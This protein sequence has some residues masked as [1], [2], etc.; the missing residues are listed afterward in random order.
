MI[1]EVERTSSAKK[2]WKSN[3]EE[4]KAVEETIKDETIEQPSGGNQIRRWWRKGHK[5]S[6]ESEEENFDS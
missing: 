1:E 3:A 4:I 6:I 2:H 5:L